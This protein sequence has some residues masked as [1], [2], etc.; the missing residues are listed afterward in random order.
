MTQYYNKTT[1][2]ITFKNSTSLNENALSIGFQPGSIV[3]MFGNQLT[4]N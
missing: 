4:V 3:D 2:W 1:F